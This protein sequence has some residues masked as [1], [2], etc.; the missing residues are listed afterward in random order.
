MKTIEQAAK[1]LVKKIINT[2][3]DSG[4]RINKQDCIAVARLII[5]TH[6]YNENDSPFPTMDSWIENDKF[7]LSIKQEIEK[8]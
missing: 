1:E 8:L 3:I 5:E 2:L 6:L 7:W 4:A